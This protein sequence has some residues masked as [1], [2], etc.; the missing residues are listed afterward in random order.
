LKKLDSLKCNHDLDGRF[1]Y[2]VLMSESLLSRK[3]FPK[4]QKAAV[5]S[6][7]RKPILLQDITK[8]NDV[9]KPSECSN[10]EHKS[11]AAP[12]YQKIPDTVSHFGPHLLPNVEI[13]RDLGVRLPNLLNR[14]DDE[15]SI[16]V[17]KNSIDQSCSSIP[18]KV[19][20][21][22]EELVTARLE[23]QPQCV[24]QFRNS[25]VHYEAREKS[26]PWKEHLDFTKHC[27]PNLLPPDGAKTSNIQKNSEQWITNQ[28]QQSKTLQPSNA[29]RQKFKEL[30]LSFD[31]ILGLEYLGFNV[32]RLLPL[33]KAPRHADCR[34]PSSFDLDNACCYWCES[35][36]HIA[37]GVAYI[38]KDDAMVVGVE[39]EWSRTSGDVVL[40]QIA[41]ADTVLLVPLRTGSPSAPK[42]LQIIFRDSWIVKTGVNI[43]KK[44]KALWVQFQIE[45]N[46]YVELND[47][48]QVSSARFKRLSDL[49]KGLLPLQA[50]AIFLGFKCWKTPEMNFSDF[51]RGSLSL[52]QLRYAAKNA[53]VTIQIFWRII[54]GSKISK[55]TNTTDLLLKIRQFV[56][57]ACAQGPISERNE[58]IQLEP[59]GLSHGL[60]SHQSQIKTQ[61]G[62]GDAFSK[63]NEYFHIQDEDMAILRDLHPA[64]YRSS[65]KVSWGRD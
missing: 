58:N 12:S 4:D 21:F 46:S 30:G 35:P 47:L 6:R 20:H 18:Q 14:T 10:V 56:G 3:K 24:S 57:S 1:Y 28:S 40:L 65:D 9:Q 13:L 5:A 8:G 42:A 61:T 17:S 2:Y 62:I 38:M 60:L 26:T 50:I 52:K 36:Q 23:M 63:A 53:L 51:D 31:Q 49:H 34:I 15:K 43:E 64:S 7:T 37:Y 32:S 59:A 16:K 29:E 27:S 11:S 48:L 54:L 45:S 33:R 19:V 22:C 25:R 41:T 39:I 55:P 44:L